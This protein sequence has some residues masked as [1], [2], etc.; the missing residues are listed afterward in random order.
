MRTGASTFRRRHARSR[1]AYR[2]AIRSDA[3]LRTTVLPEESMASNSDVQRYDR[4]AIALHWL[5]AIGVIVMIGLGWYMTGIP[6]GAPDRAV[7]FNLHKSIGLTLGIIVLIRVAW[8]WTHTPPPLPAG[9]ASWVVNGAKLSHGLLYALL[10][11]MPAAGFIASN[12]NKYGIT[13]FGLFKI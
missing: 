6:K 4:V 9:T 10:I 7:Y 11:L 1:S 5:V 8:R 13:Y 3:D 12:F 2:L